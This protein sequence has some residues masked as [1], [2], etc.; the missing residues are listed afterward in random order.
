MKLMLPYTDEMVGSILSRACRQ[1]GLKPMTLLAALTGRRLIRQSLVVT[2][3]AGIAEAC[4]MSLDEFHLRHTIARYAIAFTPEAQQERLW[5]GLLSGNSRSNFVVMFAPGI[6]KRRVHLQY[7]PSCTIEDRRSFGES[8]WHRMHQ[9]PGVTICIT[10]RRPLVQCTTSIVASIPIPMPHLCTAWRECDVPLSRRLQIS[11]AE[12]SAIAVAGFPGI[13]RS[14]MNW[15]REQAI[16]C[17]YHPAHQTLFSGFIASDL[18]RFYG[19]DALAALNCSVGSN[20][21]S[22]WAAR[23]MRPNAAGTSSLKHILLTVF[24][25]S[26]P[27]PARDAT[28]SSN[29]KKPGE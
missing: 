7:C 13:N 9:L 14:W 28:A 22:C 3:Q 1:F 8:Y 26:G 23:L 21:A 5:Q 17:G 18:A 11:I 25:E 29:T 10:H 24:L 15:Y 12:W 4:G 20:T 27:C 6:P 16:A 19:Q 2:C